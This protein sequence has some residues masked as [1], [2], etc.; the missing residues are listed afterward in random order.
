MGAQLGLEGG[1]EP[2][3]ASPVRGRASAARHPAA[4][5]PA[6][7]PAA[8]KPV[9]DALAPECAGPVIL[10]VEAALDLRLRELRRPS[11]P[12]GGWSRSRPSASQGSPRRP[13]GGAPSLPAT[14]FGPSGQRPATPASL[15]RLRGRA[16]SPPAAPGRPPR[17]GP[18]GIRRTWKGGRTSRP[19]RSRRSRNDASGRPRAAR[20]RTAVGRRAAGV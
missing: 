2:R 17:R 4:N 10:G 1:P 15:G 9:A 14:P 16:A 6:I 7:S 19:P 13:R 18:T 3:G 5:A 8:G 11:T 20:R 12:P